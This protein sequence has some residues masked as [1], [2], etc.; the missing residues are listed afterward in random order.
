MRRLFL[1]AT[2]SVVTFVSSILLSN[3]TRPGTELAVP[4][5]IEPSPVSTV[6]SRAP[7]ADEMELREIYRQYGPAQNRHDT[8]FFERIEAEE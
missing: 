3:F 1:N 2:V 4:D 5:F 7:S 6:L 8:K